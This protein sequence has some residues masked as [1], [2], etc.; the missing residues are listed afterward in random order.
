MTE[1]S[2]ENL[3]EVLFKPHRSSLETSFISNS[4]EEL[5]P[6]R[7][8]T[9]RRWFRELH[10]DYWSWM[11][12]DILEIQKA[13]ADISGSENKRTR[14]GVL[15]TVYEYGPGNWVYEF[16]MLAEK[17]SSYAKSI[18]E[19]PGKKEEAFKHFRLAYLCYAMASYPHLQGDEMANHALL[20]NHLNYKKVASYLSGHFEIIKFK[21]EAGEGT[22]YVHT[23]DRFKCLPCVIICG[24]YINLATEYLR[25]YRENLFPNGIAMITLDLPGM[26]MNTGIT[27]SA[28]TGVL[29]EAVLDYVKEKL[30]YIDRS[31]IGIVAQRFGCNCAAH[32]LAT[33]SSDIKAACMIAPIV[34]DVL[35]DPELLKL[36]SPIQ[37]ASMC[38]RMGTDAAEW[39]QLIPRLQIFSVKRQGLLS[40]L[41]LSKPLLVVTS[42]RKSI[43][44]I[45]DAKLIGSISDKTEFMELK[46]ATAFEL[47]T[48]VIDQI[49]DWLKERL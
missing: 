46:A 2:S 19:D 24:N 39:E 34:N 23:P 13:L 4:V 45:G 28:N 44:T 27:L 40:G 16:S 11:G 5:L 47:F 31:R 32:L 26:G 41:K 25:F 6:N 20:M 3:S 29:H 14:E 21:S 37:R 36:A 10:R 12:L 22:A 1:I 8:G 33:H 18:E 30:P 7:D 15:D 35:V 17:H 48:K 42:D 9:P 38:N 49:T 43:S